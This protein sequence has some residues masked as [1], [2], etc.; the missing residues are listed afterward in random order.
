MLIHVTFFLLQCEEWDNS[1]RLGGIPS[2]PLS[3]EVCTFYA[4]RYTFVLCQCFWKRGQHNG[5]KCCCSWEYSTADHIEIFKQAAFYFIRPCNF[6][7]HNIWTSFRSVSACQFCYTEVWGHVC[8]ILYE[9]TSCVCVYFCN[10][11]CICKYQFRCGLT[12]YVWMYKDWENV[13]NSIWLGS[14]YF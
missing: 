13:V 7:F 4:R 11:W 8:I 10:L 14:V 2:L 9:I 12:V 6:W 5:N 1:D 3:W